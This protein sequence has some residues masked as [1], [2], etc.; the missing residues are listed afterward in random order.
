MNDYRSTGTAELTSKLDKG[1]LI[2]TMNRPHARNALTDAMAE[3]LQAELCFAEAS[4]KVRCIVL[5]GAENA[6]CAG[7]DLKAMGASL[8]EDAINT[9]VRW[10]CRV[11]RDTAGL[12]YR[13]PKPTL[14]VVNGP[15]AGAGLSLALSCDLRL[16][17]N[18]AF[19]LSAFAPVGLSG[20]FGIA[21]FLTRLIGS[22]KARELMFLSDRIPAAQALDLGLVNWTCEPEDL[23]DRASDIS[24]RLAAGPATALGY[25]KENLNRAVTSP[26]EDC[27]NLE[28][29]HHIHCMATDDHHEG[30]AEFVEKRPPIFGRCV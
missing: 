2:L 26:L 30:I 5:Q 20:D 4:S 19:L 8:D 16:M 1:V 6:F 7:G 21:Y 9:R 24:A 10:Q 12:L 11:Q 29:D 13:M 15:A 23:P 27:M 14:A 25:M 17:V 28:A 18:S 22:A 3:A